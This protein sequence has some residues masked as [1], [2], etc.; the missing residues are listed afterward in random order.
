MPPSSVTHQA[1]IYRFTDHH[2]FVL[3]IIFSG[4][5]VMSNVIVIVLTVVIDLICVASAASDVMK[6]CARR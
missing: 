3:I 6:R 4:G 2:L 1:F 5:F